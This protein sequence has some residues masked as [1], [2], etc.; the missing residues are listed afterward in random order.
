MKPLVTA[1]RKTQ[2]HCLSMAVPPLHMLAVR[3]VINTDVPTRSSSPLQN[4]F[5]TF[6][7]MMLP[8]LLSTAAKPSNSSSFPALFCS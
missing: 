6:T 3:W 8:V 1:Y 5:S 4:G 2:P 7:A